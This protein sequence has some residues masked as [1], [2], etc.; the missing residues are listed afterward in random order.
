MAAPITTYTSY[1]EIR[2]TLGVDSTDLED[3]TLAL[4]IYAKELEVDLL[5]LD[6]DLTTQYATVKALPSPTVAQAKFLTATEL[7]AVYS[8]AKRLTTSLPLFASKQMTDGKASDTRFENT[9]K[10]VIDA[11]NSNYERTKANLVAA[12]QG[13][14]VTTG[15]TTSRVYARI[16]TPIY[17]PVTGT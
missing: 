12:Y 15:A 14:V 6:A 3:A 5:A 8:V 7:F 10:P 9:W 2:A 16:V 1:E 13:I 4:A 17:D 11:I